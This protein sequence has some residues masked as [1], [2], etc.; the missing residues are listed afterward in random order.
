VFYLL[1]VA[2]AEKQGLPVWTIP[3]NLDNNSGKGNIILIKRGASLA[4]SSRD[5][6]DELGI[7]QLELKTNN[8]KQK[9]F[10]MNFHPSQPIGIEEL[11]KKTSL[12]ISDV[13]N[14]LLELELDGKIKSL[15]NKT[16]ILA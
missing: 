9:G 5:I 14:K 10:I 16:Y 4:T 1:V 3:T 2:A 8:E 6:L 12:T 7:E 13:N 15:S 11:V